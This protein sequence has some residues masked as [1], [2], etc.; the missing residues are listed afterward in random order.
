[1]ETLKGYQFFQSELVHN[2]DVLV[3]TM[4]RPP[5]NAFVKE[6]YEE[7]SSILN[8]ATNNQHIGAIVFQS[9][10]RM[11]SAGADVKQLAEDAKAPPEVAATRR[12]F[13]RKAWNDLYTCQIPVVVALNGA[14]VG[15]GAVLAACGDIIIA[16]EDAF[17]ALPEINIGLV[18]GAKGL[19]RLLPPQKIR[20]LALTGNR[21][22]VKEVYKYGGIEEITTLENL[23]PTA[24]Q[25]AKDI[26]DKGAKTARKWKESFIL[27]SETGIGEGILIE[28]NLNQELSN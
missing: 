13:L 14:T 2:E 15:I 18:G 16:E 26:A 5:V 7:L 10:Q 23:H 27:T 3:I 20:S 8:D 11:F 22:S 12:T 28:T 6:S 21:L 9:G 24:L 25:Y 4:N 1:M 17:L 19:T